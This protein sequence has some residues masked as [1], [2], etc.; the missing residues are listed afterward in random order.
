ME[1]K[2]NMVLPQIGYPLICLRDELFLHIQPLSIEQK[3]LKLSDLRFS[4]HIL[5]S[6]CFL[7]FLEHF[8]CW[9]AFIFGPAFVHSLLRLVKGRAN[10][11]AWHLPEKSVINLTCCSLFLI[12]SGRVSSS[13]S[14]DWSRWFDTNSL[15]P[16]CSL[17]FSFMG[18]VGKK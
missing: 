5:L 15:P 8:G 17:G 7:F 11:K 16:N 9:C 1:P 12:G 14:N 4:C 10:F 6:S 18:R 2:K 3:A 13:W